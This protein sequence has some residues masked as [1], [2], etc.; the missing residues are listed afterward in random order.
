[1]LLPSGLPVLPILPT[2]IFA[3]PRAEAYECGALLSGDEEGAGGSATPVDA[4]GGSPIAEVNVRK[5]LLLTARM[6]KPRLDP[7]AAA[8]VR[9]VLATCPEW[10]PARPM[11]LPYFRWCFFR[12]D[13]FLG[14]GD[15]LLR[16]LGVPRT[17]DGYLAWLARL[18]PEEV[19][20]RVLGAAGDPDAGCED[21]RRWLLEAPVTTAEGETGRDFADGLRAA[22]GAA[23]QQPL[24]PDAVRLARERRAEVSLLLDHLTRRKRRLVIQRF[25]LD[26]RG[27]ATL[28]ELAEAENISRSRMAQILKAALRKLAHGTGFDDA[29]YLRWRLVGRRPKRD[30]DSCAA[31]PEKSLL[32]GAPGAE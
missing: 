13:L 22:T 9:A 17:L 29:G 31:V 21:D 16:W 1:M 6:E 19:A 14:R 11:A 12:H 2:E 3:G 24:W 27:G 18:F 4:R 32:K 15:F 10:K 26:E 5:R 20:D 8:D 7:G 23:E 25:G 28:E 30:H